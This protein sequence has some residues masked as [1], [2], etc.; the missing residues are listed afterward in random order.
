MA[1]DFTYRTEITR[2]LNR[3]GVSAAPMLRLPL[4]SI[5][6]DEEYENYDFDLI[7]TRRRW[8]IAR[9]LKAAG[10]RQTSG[11]ILTPEDGGEPV[12]YPKPG[13]LGTD[14]SRPANDLLGRGGGIVMV[15]PTQALLLYLHHFGRPHGAAALQEELA[16]LVW[17][18]PANFEKVAQWARPAGLQGVFK[19]LRGALEGPQAEGIALRKRRRFESRLPH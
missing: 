18:Q 2:H 14:P 5:F 16:T 17:E 11:R 7:S 4:I 3:G 6:D 9:L 13:G 15:T 8:R 1:D 19:E 10:F 12:I